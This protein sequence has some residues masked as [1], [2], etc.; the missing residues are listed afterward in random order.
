MYYSWLSVGIE[1][2]NNKFFIKFRDSDSGTMNPDRELDRH[3]NLIDYS[4]GHAPPLQKVHQNLFI[5]F[6]QSNGQTD[7]QT[8][9]QTKTEV[10]NVTCFVRR[11]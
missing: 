10:K 3:Q 6:E 4:L 9:R 7:G 1:T 2:V 11:R 8:N 5:T